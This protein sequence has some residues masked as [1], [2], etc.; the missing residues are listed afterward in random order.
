MDRRFIGVT[1]VTL[2]CIGSTPVPVK[3]VCVAVPLEEQFAVSTVVFG[4]VER[5][6]KRRKCEKKGR[7]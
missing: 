4:W 1:L 5:R 3:A 6:L 2:S 7:R